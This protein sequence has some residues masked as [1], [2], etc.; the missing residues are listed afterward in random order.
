MRKLGYTVDGSF[1]IR[2]ENQLKLVVFLPLFTMGFIHPSCL[3]G[4]SSI[5]SMYIVIFF[6]TILDTTTSPKTKM[7]T[8]ATRLAVKQRVVGRFFFF[9]MKIDRINR[10]FFVIRLFRG[11]FGGYK[12]YPCWYP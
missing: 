11:A 6:F 7:Q 1:E 9:R 8:L 5:S 4:I 2:R 10:L 12:N 3:F